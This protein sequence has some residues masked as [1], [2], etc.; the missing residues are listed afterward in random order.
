L[1]DKAKVL[2]KLKLPITIVCSGDDHVINKMP[3]KGFAKKLGKGQ[4]IEINGA[5]H[6]VLIEAD[7]YR[8]EAME[9]FDQLADFV[10]PYALSPQMRGAVQDNRADYGF[11]VAAADIAEVA[12]ELPQEISPES[13]IAE[14]EI[15]PDLPDPEGQKSA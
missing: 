4:Y 7:D 15:L 1:L 10:S 5:E 3:T 14:E 12:S 13:L 2:K 6:E 11:G 9:A 8:R